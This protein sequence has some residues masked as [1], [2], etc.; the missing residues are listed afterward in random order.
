MAKK[1][2]EPTLQGHP[3][4]PSLGLRQK[5]PFAQPINYSGRGAAI[6]EE[7]K[8]SQKS[9]VTPLQTVLNPGALP[10]CCELGHDG[11]CG[12]GGNGGPNRHKFD[13]HTNR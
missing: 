3:C 12:N 13:M 10:R 4:A 11:Q 2:S 7:S 5:S 1:N 9:Q 8:I 6:P